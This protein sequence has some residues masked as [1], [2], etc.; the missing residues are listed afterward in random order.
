MAAIP[1]STPP[2]INTTLPLPGGQCYSLGASDPDPRATEVN[3]RSEVQ[4]HENEGCYHDMWDMRDVPLEPENADIWALSGESPSSA[5]HVGPDQVAEPFPV[6]GPRVTDTMIPTEVCEQ[7]IDMAYIHD[8]TKSVDHE[9]AISTMQSCALVCRAS[10]TR[11]QRWIF[12]AVRI[13]DMQTLLK[14]SSHLE[15]EPRL[16][17]FVRKVCVVGESVH[18]PASPATA[19]PLLLDRR[20]PN[21]TAVSI[22]R[23]LD[24]QA[25]RHQE[26]LR[27][28]LPIHPR[29]P[30]SF[31]AFA[32]LDDL[33]LEGVVFPSFTDFAR[34]IQSI[35]GVSGL[36]CIRV[37]W[38]APSIPSSGQQVRPLCPPTLKRL[39]VSA[40][41][42][43]CWAVC[44]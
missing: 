8:F 14:F 20:L 39:T 7:I 26:S 42:E 12:H 23:P 4:L 36:T 1:M 18:A 9:L 5:S 10:R 3:I 6:Q 33:H 35:D 38:S 43:V 37:R 2:N 19:L 17:V 27:Q 31:R 29:F 15:R 24:P 25:S 34:C 13:E 22:I 32:A 40:R 16:A 44:G 41:Y 28:H 21:L 11:S 30:L